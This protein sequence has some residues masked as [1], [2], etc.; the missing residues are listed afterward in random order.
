VQQLEQLTELEGA[1]RDAGT[2]YIPNG[3][4][5]AP[6]LQQYAEELGLTFTSLGSTPK[7]DLASVRPVRIGLWDRYGGSMAS[8]WMRWTL[9]QF[10]FD[11]QVVFPPE[12]DKGSLA[13]RYDVLIFVGGAIPQSLRGRK[14]RLPDKESIPEEYHN[15]IGAI[16]ADKTLPQLKTFLEQGGVILTIGSS[17]SLARHLDLPVQNAL[18]EVGSDRKPQSLGREKFYVPGSVLRARLDTKNRLTFG[19]AEHVDVF[20]KRSPAFRLGP[21]AVLRGLRPVA[22]FD[23]ET[24]LRSGWAWGQH[25]LKDAMA[26]VTAPVGK[27]ALILYGPEIAYRAQPHGTFKLLFNG[28]YYRSPKEEVSQAHSDS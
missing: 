18:V 9:E 19:A 11:F 5:V 22:W 21:E 26:I 7:A 20:F 28:I 4:E 16:T 14:P 25:Y 15:R 17:T 24:P 6:T 3:S 27:G 12:L 23:S 2:W 10:E 1:T 13:S 8:G